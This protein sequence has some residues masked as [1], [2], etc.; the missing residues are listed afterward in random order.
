MEADFPDTIESTHAAR[1]GSP[2]RK[3]MCGEFCLSLFVMIG[4]APA[5]FR[6]MFRGQTKRVAS[7]VSDPPL[8]RL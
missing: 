3:K 7:R 2:W 1:S 8:H 5:D 6:F 4:E